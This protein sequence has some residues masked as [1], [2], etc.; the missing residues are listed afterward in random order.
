MK[1]VLVSL[2]VIVHA[3]SLTA[4]IHV[5]PGGS[6]AG[7][8]T[9]SSPFLT[10]NHAATVAAAGNTIFVHAGV[11][12]DEQGIV[13]LGTKDL[14]LQGD[15]AATTVLHPHTV[16][17][18]PLAAAE[19]SGGAPVAHRV[20][21][22]LSGTARVHLRDFT[23]DAQRLV[24]P[25][26]QLAGLYLRGGVDVVC[27]HL[28][29]VECRPAVWG[30]GLTQGIA[31]RGDVPTDPTTVVVRDGTFL[32]FG[33]AAVRALLRA[34]IDL[35]G[36]SIAGSREEPGVVDQVGAWVEASAIG[37]VRLSRLTGLGGS[38]GA[39][40]RLDGHGSGCNVDGNRVARAAFGVDV[41]HA[42]AAIVP[43]SVRDNRI[44]AVDTTVRVRG[45]SGLI[46]DGNSLFPV[47]RFDPAPYWDD[48]RLGA[49]P[50]SRTATRSRRARRAW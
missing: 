6:D 13:Q 40:V 27:D 3:A 8:G 19:P 11:Y 44:A 48:T 18:V 28:R 32:Q 35:Q 23:I 45:V 46:L 7:A 2:F 47:S 24:P 4:Q 31:V 41:H 49:T 38:A 10:I 34:E 33:N 25:S 14:V 50:G 43:G 26:G 39:A 21:M 12:G 37:S 22:L 42:P 30:V 1:S 29:I 20:G 17:T 5:A 9:V 16:A 15:G 36:C